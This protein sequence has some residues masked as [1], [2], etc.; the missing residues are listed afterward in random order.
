VALD[1]DHDFVKVFDGDEAGALLVLGL[2]GHQRVLL[3]KV[4]QKLGELGVSD[5]PCLKAKKFFKATS[6]GILKKPRCLN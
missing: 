4:V 2:E 1:G 6:N 3:V 5:V